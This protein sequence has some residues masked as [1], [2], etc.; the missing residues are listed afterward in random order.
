M[1]GTIS[2]WLFNMSII[3]SLM[4][5]IV[6]LIRKI[7]R[8]P[9]RFEIILWI[10]PFLRMVV[11]FGINSPFGLMALISKFTTRTVT[12]YETKDSFELSMTNSI[13]AAKSYSPITYEYNILENIFNIAGL[14]WIIIATALIMTLTIMYV[15]TKK[16]IKDSIPLEGNVYLSDKVGSPA[17]Y[18]VIKPRIIIPSSYENTD[19][20]YII[21]HEKTHI[22]RGDNFWRLLG[23][24]VACVHW[25][26]PL[27]WIFLNAFLEDLEIACDESSVSKLDIEE[28]KEYARTLLNSAS[29]KNVFVS[30]FGGAK[31][32]TRIESVL[33][34][35]RMTVFSAIGFSVLII[36][37]IFALVTNAG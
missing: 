29:G 30:A 25:F 19:L 5:L 1:F 27:S 4:G 17:V 32:R 20:K 9:R 35:K 12:V 16:E 22:K 23:F 33:S 37:I 8:I 3:A 21:R 18:G 7:K 15:I 31:V 36:A 14:V 34:Y 28:R 2:Y 10:I 11:P 6:M 13:M 26:N 24:M